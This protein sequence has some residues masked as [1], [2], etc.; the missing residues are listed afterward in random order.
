MTIFHV[1]RSSYLL[2]LN[3]SISY[4]FSIAYCWAIWFTR[5]KRIF[6]GKK[7]DPRASAAKAE[8]LLEAYHRARKTDASHIH[9]V[10]RVVQKKWE[11]PPGN[12]LKVNVDAAINCRNQVLGLGAVIKDPSGKIVAAG[13]KQVP[14]REGVSFA[15]AE[16]MEW[17]LKVAKEFSLS[18]MIMEIDCKEVVDLLNNT[19]GSRTCISWVIS[20]IQEQRRDFK[21][22]KFRHIPRTCNTCAHSLAKLVVGANTSAIWLDHIPAEILNVLNNVV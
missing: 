7:S 14:L 1:S 22:V 6:E 12:F 4:H 8:S 10:K 21:E 16:A 18:A 17:G 13:I 3:V 9:N 20:D 2:W 11:P 5:N 19:K 15:E